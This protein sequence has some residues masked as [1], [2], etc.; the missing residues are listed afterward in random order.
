[1]CP[2]NQS[3][4]D[5]KTCSW[6]KETKPIS[7]FWRNCWA[8]DGLHSHCKDCKRAHR[9]LT[10]DRQK[11]RDQ[12][13]RYYERNRPRIIESVLIYR[14]A[15]KQGVRAWQIV[16]KRRPPRQPCEVCGSLTTEAH[17]DDYSKPLDIR[18]LC[19]IHH[20]EHHLRLNQGAAK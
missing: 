13:R 15:N 8:W 14:K 12:S 7:E 16:R 3:A 17:H 10:I 5:V 6:C 2:K 11:K 4:T 19:R 1:M 9:L 20:R 18:W